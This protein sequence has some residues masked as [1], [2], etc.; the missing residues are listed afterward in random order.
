MK[1]IDKVKDQC[2]GYNNYKKGG[3]KF[4]L[5][6]CQSCKYANESLSIGKFAH[7]QDWLI[8]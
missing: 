6:M 1:S 8:D 5:Q 7:L 3:H 2:Q 4:I